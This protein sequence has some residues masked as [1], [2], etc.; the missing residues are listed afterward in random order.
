MSRHGFRRW[1]PSLT[2]CD[3]SVFADGSLRALGGRRT[4]Q[5]CQRIAEMCLMWSS[6]RVPAGL[7][8]LLIDKESQSLFM[9]HFQRPPTHLPPDL[10]FM[11]CELAMDHWQDHSS[12]R[13]RDCPKER[14]MEESR[15]APDSLR[16][17][18]IT[19]LSY[20]C[21]LICQP[22]NTTPLPPPHFVFSPSRSIH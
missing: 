12:G 17:R 8:Q 9:L 6:V 3:F 10:F 15:L 7:H 22:H 11:L 20:Q 1:S 19:S 16:S 21:T 5:S 2:S 14:Q 13:Y 4:A 18:L